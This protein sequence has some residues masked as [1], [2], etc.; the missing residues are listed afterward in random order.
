MRRTFSDSEVDRM[1]WYPFKWTASE[2]LIRANEPSSNIP[3]NKMALNVSMMATDGAQ[4]AAEGALLGEGCLQGVVCGFVENHV[5][6]QVH[7]AIIDQA[8]LA[9]K[10][11][12]GERAFVNNAVVKV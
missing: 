5:Q 2:I 4:G 6:V 7:D 8:I 3:S 12:P 11:I 1:D 10:P 9:Y